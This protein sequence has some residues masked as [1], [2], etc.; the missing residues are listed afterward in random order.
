M[1]KAEFEAL[2]AGDSIFHNGTGA[3]RKILSVSRIR[4]KN[5]YIMLEKLKG[6]SAKNPTR[7]CIYN[8]VKEL[9]R[10]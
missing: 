8:A 6:K 5:K 7:A 9:Y 1:T 2:K 10:V 3:E 4:N